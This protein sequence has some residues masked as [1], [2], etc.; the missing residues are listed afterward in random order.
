MKFL[1]KALLLGTV[2]AVALMTWIAVF[3][4]FSVKIGP[5]SFSALSLTGSKVAMERPKLAGFRGDGQPYSMTAER[6]LQDIKN[7]TVVEL[8][9]MVG[10]IGTAGGGAPTHIK[11][12]SGIY[13]SVNERMKLMDNIR[14]ANANLEI[15]LRAANIDFKTGVYV[16]DEPVEVHVGEGT[17]ISADRASA[18]NNGQELTFEGHVRTRVV[19]EQTGEAA[20]GDA[21]AKGAKP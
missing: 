12:D 5:L 3:D 8:Q 6:A 2:T 15:F 13:D 18:R 17:T 16:S 10:E 4:P 21:D 20:A 11:A 7:P 9:K 1:R 14:I 19:S